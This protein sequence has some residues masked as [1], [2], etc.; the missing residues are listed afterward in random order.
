MHILQSLSFRCSLSSLCTGL[1]FSASCIAVLSTCSGV[2]GSSLVGSA[3]EPRRSPRH[4]VGRVGCSLTRTSGLDR[5]Y[6]L[7]RTHPS[8]GVG[9]HPPPVWSTPGYMRKRAALDFLLHFARLRKAQRGAKRSEAMPSHATPRQ[10]T[11]ISKCRQKNSRKVGSRCRSTHTRHASKRTIEETNF[12][13][14]RPRFLHRH[15]SWDPN[16]FRC[17]VSASTRL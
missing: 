14:S 8:V 12:T 4:G 17:L 16:C 2:T 3:D 5:E 13:T 1:A 10:T 7:P 11:P 6:A 9:V 15:T